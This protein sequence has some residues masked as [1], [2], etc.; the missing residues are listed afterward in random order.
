MAISRPGIE[1]IHP[2]EPALRAMPGWPWPSPGPGA[3]PRDSTA[4][5]YAYRCDRPIAGP[6]GWGAAPPSW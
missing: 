5:W 1:N 4:G 3:G 6:H 2:Q